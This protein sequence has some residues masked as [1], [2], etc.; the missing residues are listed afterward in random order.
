MKDAAGG[1][2]PFFIIHHSAFIIPLTSSWSSLEC[3]PACHAGDRGFKSHRGRL[4]G[5]VRQSGRATD[6]KRPWMWVRLPP[7][8]LEQQHA[9]VGHWQ[10]PLAVNQSSE[11]TLAVQLRPGAPFGGCKY[12]RRRSCEQIARTSLMPADSKARPVLL[13]AQDA[14]PSF[15]RYGFD[16]RTGCFS[17]RPTILASHGQMAAAN[18]TTGASAPEKAKWRNR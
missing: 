8:L 17:A 18:V 7:V 13:M 6:L 11:W 10:A 12:E 5:T 9:S 15:S 14:R 1:K 4:Y 2:C 3:S 16:S